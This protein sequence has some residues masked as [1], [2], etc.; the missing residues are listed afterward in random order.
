MKTR[1]NLLIL[2]LALVSSAVATPAHALLLWVAPTIHDCA[3]AT[4]DTVR[5]NVVLSSTGIFVDAGGFDVTYDS[6]KLGFIRAERGDLT[7]SWPTF[8]VTSGANI[9]ISGAGPTI[10]KD[11]AG[12][13]ATLIF[14]DKC[15]GFAAT[16][17]VQLCIVNRTGDLAFVPTQCGI[18]ACI[19]NQPGSL[20]V[21]TIYRTCVGASVDTVEVDVGVENPP[22]AIDAAGVDIA[23]NSTLLGYVGYRRGDLTQA[24]PF[25][26]AVLNGSAVR[27]GGFTSTAVPAGTSGVFVTLR[28]V[29][30]VAFGNGASSP[31][32]SQLLVDDFAP[33]E[34]LCGAI[35]CTPLRTQPSSW[36][37]VK[38]L[39][40]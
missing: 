33:L 3:F 28:F 14:V 19:P 40:R 5:V 7:A 4:D 18:V 11:T 17:N 15:C 25:F 8:D 6:N 27:V 32:C 24:W 9:T 35:T 38:S 23:F 39:Y 16:Q 30:T 2:A 29:T 13:F 21:E 31:L 1:F 37:Y 22:Q 34:P 26:D 10:P 20:T 36:G 12:S